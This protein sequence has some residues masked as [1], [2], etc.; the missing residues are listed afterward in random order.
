MPCFSKLDADLP[1]RHPQD[2][3]LANPLALY[4]EKAPSKIE[5]G[6]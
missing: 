6:L 2:A 3:A 1:A 4:K 5:R